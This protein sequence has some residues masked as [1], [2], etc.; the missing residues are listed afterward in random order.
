MKL[1]RL[2]I[3][4]FLCVF[5]AVAQDDEKEKEEKRRYFQEFGVL[6]PAQIGINIETQFPVMPDA[7]VKIKFG[8]CGVYIYKIGLNLIEM[9]T[10]VRNFAR[11]NC[12]K[13]LLGIDYSTTKQPKHPK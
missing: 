13:G 9:L 5:S 8:L 10:L 3:L 12:K 11:R 2:L 7:V 4:M 1:F 6:F